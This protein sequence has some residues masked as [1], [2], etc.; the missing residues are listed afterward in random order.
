MLP[1]PAVSPGPPS[2]KNEATLIGVVGVLRTSPAELGYCLAHE[3]W[4]QGY[5]TEA[6][7]LFLPLYWE[8]M[9]H[10][11]Y[12]QAKVDAENVASVKILKKFGFRECE[13]LKGAFELVGKGLRDMVIYRLDRPANSC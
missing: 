1:S 8:R 5:A 12:V 4:G 6:V 10:V 3:Y 2:S 7:G 9:R 11:S 13:V